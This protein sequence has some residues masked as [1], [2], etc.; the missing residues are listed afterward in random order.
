MA[1]GVEVKFVLSFLRVQFFIGG[2][3]MIT[4]KLRE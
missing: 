1:G 3:G 2:S 4:E